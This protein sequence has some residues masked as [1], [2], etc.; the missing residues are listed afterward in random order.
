M[1]KKNI[2]TISVG[3][4]F[5]TSKKEVELTEKHENIFACVGQHPEGAAKPPYGAGSENVIGG[6]D[7]RISELAKNP[8]VVAIG[9]CGL[10]YFRLTENVEEIKKT[11]KEIFEKQ[12]ELSLKVGKP[13]MIHI[14]PSD[15]INFDAY[16]DALEILENYAK[17][18]GGKLRGNAH[19]FVGNVEVLKRFLA[20]DFTVS[21]AGVVTFTDEYNEVI[22]Y[23][24]I[25]SIMSETDA[26]YVAPVPHRG[27][28]NS[29][30]FIPE[31]VAAIAS[32]RD[33]SPNLVQKT[34]V[35]NAVKFFNLA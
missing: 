21:F 2:G 23:A 4:D 3:V 31:I 11:Q 35:E 6:F 13:L 22:R 8:K 12:I 33:D 24:P 32:I 1:K 9:E 28:R 18:H 16:F 27:K 10:D 30:L 15:K 34:L 17:K 19:F 26:P 14:R 7:E 5:E 20:I 29:P 25:G